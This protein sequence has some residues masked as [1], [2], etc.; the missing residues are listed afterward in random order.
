MGWIRLIF[1]TALSVGVGYHLSC[2]MDL[3]VVFMAI[4]SPQD[5][6]CQR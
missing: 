2:R 4:D 6:E 5:V 1:M 3:E